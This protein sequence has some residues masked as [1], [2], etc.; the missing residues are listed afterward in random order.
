M[1]RVDFYLLPDRA[2]NSRPLL[3]CRLTEK[4]F[5]LGH[6]VYIHVESTQQAQYLDDLLWTFRQGSFIPHSVCP[7]PDG[8]DMPVLIGWRDEPEGAREVLVNLTH[9]APAFFERF[10]RVAELV[11]QDERG[12]EKSF[13]PINNNNL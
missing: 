12:L 4:A 5:S 1:A 13:R 3:A 6:R 10:D 7:A 2:P 8:D 9:E 11:D